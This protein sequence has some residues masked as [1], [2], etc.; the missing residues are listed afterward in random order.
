MAAAVGAVLAVAYGARVLKEA[1]VGDRV[2]PRIP[3]A[4]L[5]ERL[6]VRILGV[7]VLLLGVLPHLLLA[8]TAPAVEAVLAR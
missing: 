6:S 5:T 4:V 2:E 3:D 1:W 8:V 7:L